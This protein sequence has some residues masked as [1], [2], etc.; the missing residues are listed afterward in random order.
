M[1]QK[2]I[3][4]TEFDVGVFTNISRDHIN[5]HHNFENYLNAKKGFVDSLVIAG[6]GGRGALAF[7]FDDPLVREVGEDFPGRK[8]SFGLGEGADLSASGVRADLRGTSMTLA[9][10]EGQVDIELKL[11]GMFSV[12][13]ALAAASAAFL[14]GIAA[15][16]I[17]I[18]L[19]RLENV[20]GRF[21]VVSDSSDPVVVVDYAH[22]PDALDNILSFCRELKP[23][24][25]ITVFG[26]GGDRDR[27]KRP[28]MGEIAC[29]YSDSV[30]LTNDNPRSEEPL[31]IIDEILS[32]IDRKICTVNVIT[33]R[34]KAIRKGVAEGGRGDMVLIAGKGHEEVQVIGRERLKFSD[35]EEARA[36]LA[37]K[38]GD[39]P[40]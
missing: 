32:G 25:L 2:R 34:R 37:L 8:I 23:E 6:G 3:H 39:S 4:G 12:Y 16:D 1:D 36:A 15:E 30:Y 5:Y 17:R 14:L 29:D 9:M 31:A 26:C 22:T 28:M 10:P 33:D 7:N 24:R 40:C 19:E 13:N 11:L 18:G 35:L 21:Q 38:R 27:G 20:P